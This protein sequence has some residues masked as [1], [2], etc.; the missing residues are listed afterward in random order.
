MRLK[1]TGSL[2]KLYG[3]GRKAFVL[4][5]VLV[6]IAFLALAAY[7]YNDLMR[8]EYLASHGA[9]RSAESRAL[10]ESGLNYSMAVLFAGQ[11]QL[12]VN[13][14]QSL[15][16]DPANR[17]PLKGSFQIIQ[18]EEES[19]KLNLNSL[20][21]LDSSGDTLRQVLEKVQSTIPEMTDDVI[22]AIIDWMDEDDDLEEQGAET[23]Y[24]MA[25]DPPY[26][27]KN[28]PVDSIEELL[29]VR[30][31]TPALLNG[32]GTSPGL[33]SL[34]TVNTR[35]VNFESDGTTIVRLNEGDLTTLES[36]L[37]TALGE[38]SVSQFIMAYRLYG[39]TKSS[40]SSG[41]SS[42]AGGGAASSPSSG[43]SSSTSGAS[44][45]SSSTSGGLGS[46]SSQ[47]PSTG[48]SGPSS[49]SGGP[50]GGASSS[51]SS[52]ISAGG[53]AT[54]VSSGGTVTV[55]ASAG[56]TAPQSSSITIVDPAKLQTQ[57]DQDKQPNFFRQLKKVT[58][59]F[60]LA[61]TDVTVSY[62]SGN[63]KV[64]GTLKSPLKDPSVASQYLPLLFSA[65]STASAPDSADKVELPAKLNVMAAP[66]EVLS[67]LPGLEDQDIQNILTNRPQPGDSTG[68]TL[69]WL[70]TKAQISASKLSRVEK[71]LTTRPKMV[72]VVSVG[73]LDGFGVTTVLEGMIDLSGPRPRLAG[74]RDLS[75]V[76]RSD[77]SGQSP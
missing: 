29:L 36:G 7:R 47:K 77:D 51:G 13:T 19:A 52:S 14:S 69:A 20:L 9:Q 27:A 68:D 58:S 30:G 72:R 8:S 39:N 63:Q 4:L 61:S 67:L 49:S 57:I 38:P 37:S 16:V 5:T 12:A 76:Y 10:A 62:Q 74:I 34:F 32:S 59:I 44:G 22:A 18:V 24:Y 70:L 46:S 17:S 55:T 23:E 26:R 43:G 25:L 11:G 71:Y 54:I 73:K 31:V 41:G 40:G 3:R 64:S 60:D 56:A 28:A 65:T 21:D 35:E 48:S 53:T 45:G 42:S 75:D 50:S 15:E 66:Y 1:E 33:K 6:V 2:P